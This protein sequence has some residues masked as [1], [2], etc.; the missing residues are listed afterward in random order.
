LRRGED[1]AKTGGREAAVGVRPEPAGFEDGAAGSFIG[2]TPPNLANWSPAP[3]RFT[4]PPSPPKDRIAMT[5][6]YQNIIGTLDREQVDYEV[7]QHE[8]VW[9]CDKMAEY[10]G[11][12][13]AEILKSAVMQD[14]DGK[15]WV[16]VLPGDKKIKANALRRHLGVKSLSFAKKEAAEAAC[17]C[18]IGCIPP[19]GHQTA[20]PI[21]IDEDVFAHERGYLSPGRHD[22]SIRIPNRFLRALPG[23]RFYRTET[24]D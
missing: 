24:A 6:V 22:C 4:P 14:Q 19:F 23:A 17:G 15:M 3:G 8:D 12:R 1:Q 2:R 9:T 11:C 18:E 7:I 20:L 13:E 21:I 5:E 16:Y 10:C